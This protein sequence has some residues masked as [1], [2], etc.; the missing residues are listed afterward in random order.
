[1]SLLSM[2]TWPLTAQWD[3]I[4]GIHTLEWKSGTPPSVTIPGLFLVVRRVYSC[5]PSHCGI[6]V[7]DS[8]VKFNSHSSKPLRSV[9][10]NIAA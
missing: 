2:D 3:K 10:C 6:G 9:E 5:D 4:A 1:M 8:C 7:I